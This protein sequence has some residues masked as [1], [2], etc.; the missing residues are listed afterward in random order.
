MMNGLGNGSDC[1]QI[2]N[3]DYWALAT[4]RITIG[5]PTIAL[6]ISA[7]N[8]RRRFVPDPAKD[9]RFLLADEKKALSLSRSNRDDNLDTSIT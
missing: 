9:R 1:I 3:I 7:S 2:D 5:R 4:N 8:D 6:F